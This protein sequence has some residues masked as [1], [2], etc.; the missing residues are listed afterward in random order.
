MPAYDYSKLADIY[1]DFCV[2]DD[3]I[4]YFLDAAA[5]ARGPVLE[6]MA[7]TGRVTMPMLGAGADL[8]CVDSSPSMLEVLSRKLAGRTRRARLVCGDV[9]ALPL[10]RAFDLVVLPFRG[11]N[12]LVGEA[13]QLAALSETAR[14]L[15]AGGSFI[16]TAHNPAVRGP[17][18]DG[19][20]REVGRFQGR[21]GRTVALRL[22]TALSRQPGVVVGEQRVEVF[23]AGGR[24]LERRRVALEFSLVPARELVAMAGSVG[25]RLVR[26]VGDWNGAPFDEASSPNLIAIFEKMG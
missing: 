21:E 20:W 6:L 16:C 9:G 12:E 17:A 2:W 14:V 25:L 10:E 1:D 23:D 26:L 13:S 18:A 4:G 7:G 3:D 19:S 8:T 11:F 15:K 22:K 5:A 24:L